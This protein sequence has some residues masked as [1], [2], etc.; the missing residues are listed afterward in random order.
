MTHHM[1]IL[2]TTLHFHV[3]LTKH[4]NP[5][6]SS[7]NYLFPSQPLLS[8]PLENHTHHATALVIAWRQARRRQAEYQNPGKVSRLLHLPRAKFARIRLMLPRHC[9]TIIHT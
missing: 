5:T 4:I 7:S 9:H 2:S 6:V 8:R 1:N 3:L